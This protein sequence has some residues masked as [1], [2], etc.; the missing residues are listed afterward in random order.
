M[1]DTVNNGVDAGS[2]WSS[3][4]Q[5]IA[6]A[7]ATTAFNILSLR[8]QVKARAVAIAGT[9]DGTLYSAGRSDGLIRQGDGTQA[10][11]S[12]AGF[13]SWLILAG[14]ALVAVFV[15]KD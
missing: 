12:I 1:G 3:L 5:N 9:E 13:P 6:A 14:L 15:L 11:N 10:A 8:E 7:G 2:D 4:L